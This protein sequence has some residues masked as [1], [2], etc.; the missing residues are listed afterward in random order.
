MR[1][2]ISS[3]FC[4]ACL[5]GCGNV[6][7]QEQKSDAEP[8]ADHEERWSVFLRQAQQQPAVITVDQ[9]WEPL[10]PLSSH[11]RLLRV[12]VFAEDRL[13]TGFPTEAEVE[14]ANALQSQLL[15]KLERGNYGVF[16]GS[17]VL[18]GQKDF[19]F[20]LRAEPD[21]DQLARSVVESFTKRKAEASIQPDSAWAAYRQE[22]YPNAR[23][24]AEISNDGV[25]IR[26]QEAG[27]PL[28]APR[29]IEHWAYFKTTKA[30]SVFEDSIEEYAFRPLDY[31]TLA[32]APEP[33]GIH[34]VRND[35][36]H[37]PYIHNLTWG[38]TELAASLGGSYDG[39]ET[40]VVKPQ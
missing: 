25:L 13:P 21:A 22:L 33:Y 27:D 2:F 16:V 14:A 38:L 29:P 20:Y 6:G 37:T 3:L 1:V 26:L 35:S 4:L 11:S 18:A 36:I 34:F 30:R 40:I 8:V 9:G 24:Q 23:E 17:Q 28:N 7:P 15:Q 19:F 10:A 31:D 12:S 5:Y 39:W 32:G